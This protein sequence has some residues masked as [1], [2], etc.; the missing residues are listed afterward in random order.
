[1]Y[2]FWDG[3]KFEATYS[4]KIEALHGNNDITI[5]T[6]II[7]SYIPLLSKLLVKLTETTFSLQQDFAYVFGV[8]IPLLI[9]SSG[10][11]L[12]L[13]TKSQ[14]V[15]T[16][17]WSPAKPHVTLIVTDSIW[18]TSCSKTSP[19]RYPRLGQTIAGSLPTQG[20]CDPATETS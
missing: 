7:E 5:Q 13:I 17:Q 20:F 15:I 10:Y 19:I 2:W 18:T 1:M 3:K 6:D 4:A 9:T 12:I 8:K 11:Y 16:K 14:Q